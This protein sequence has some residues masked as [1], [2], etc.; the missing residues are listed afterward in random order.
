MAQKKNQRRSRARSILSGY[1]HLATVAKGIIAWVGTLGIV[2][3]LGF[4]AHVFLQR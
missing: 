1:D 4:I 3:L 2:A